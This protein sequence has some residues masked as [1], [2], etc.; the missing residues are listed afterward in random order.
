M[1]VEARLPPLTTTRAPTNMNLL[2]H[3]LFLFQ[4]LFRPGFLMLVETKT[5]LLKSKIFGNVGW[6]NLEN[7]FLGCGALK[8]FRGGNVSSVTNMRS[9]F[10]GAEKVTP[11]IKNWEYFIS[12]GYGL[13]V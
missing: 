4:E 8:V 5:R 9:M 10:E 1:A 2:A 3:T 13:Y 7:A 12:D 11:E 6:I